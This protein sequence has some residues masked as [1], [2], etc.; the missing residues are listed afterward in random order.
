MIYLSFSC[1][2]LVIHYNFWD[3]FFLVL[4][5]M[6]CSNFELLGI[7]IWALC[8]K[9]VTYRRKC[10]FFYHNSVLLYFCRFFCIHDFEHKNNVSSKFYLQ[11]FNI[12]EFMTFFSYLVFL[13]ML[14]SANLLENSAIKTKSGVVQQ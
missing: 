2:L 4:I 14:Q 1:V 9:K 7:A 8:D 10:N 13:A 11:T 5:Y 12:L 6:Q 3:M